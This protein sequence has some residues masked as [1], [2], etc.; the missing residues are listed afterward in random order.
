MLNAGADG[1]TGLGA[2]IIACELELS[3]GTEERDTV[4]DIRNTGLT[5]RRIE[6]GAIPG[7]ADTAAHGAKI[8]HA[9]AE[10]YC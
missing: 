5:T 8:F 10:V 3:G 1:V 9:R 6:Q 2:A 7:V 4:L